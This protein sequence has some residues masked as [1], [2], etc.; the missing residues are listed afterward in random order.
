M[1]D[2]LK[3]A[4]NQSIEQAF[5]QALE[6]ASNRQWA[7]MQTCSNSVYSTGITAGTKDKF[8][9]ITGR[10]PYIVP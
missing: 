9:S 7:L 1:R 6:Q 3:Q 4:L 2:C 10:Q 8:R 5:E